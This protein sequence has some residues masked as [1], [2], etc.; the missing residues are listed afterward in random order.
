[1]NLQTTYLGLK[2]RNPLVIG[3]SPFCDN[4]TACR[5]LAEAGVAAIVMHS[6]FEEQIG[7]TPRELGGS[8][9]GLVEGREQLSELF[10]HYEDYRLDSEQYLRQ[11]ERLRKLVD[12]PII[13]SLNGSHMGNWVGQVQRMEDAGAAAIELNPYQL[14]TD[15]SRPADDIEREIVELVRT[16]AAAVNIPVSVKLSPFHTSLAHFASTLAANG[17]A[18][19]VLFNQFYQPDIDIDALE[20]VTQLRLS[21]SSDLLLRLRWLS[22]LSPQFSGSLACSGGVHTTQDLVKALLAGADV[23][24]VVSALLRYGTGHVASLL[25]GLEAW[26]SEHEFYSVDR[27]RGQLN[28]RKCADPAVHERAHYLKV[29]QSWQV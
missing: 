4:L 16:V 8:A 12:I 26:M 27:V 28:L 17:A 14:P 10:P 5:E 29:L 19:V 11:L 7:A 3:A 20:A 25:K 1:M 13:G 24:Q 15:P 18:G 21:H 2:L 22:I 9:D 6:F 23:V